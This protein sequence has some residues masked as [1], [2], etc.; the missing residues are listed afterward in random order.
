MAAKYFYVT[1]YFD[2]LLTHTEYLHWAEI[3][4]GR[5]KRLRL[6]ILDDFMRHYAKE[7]WEMYG[8]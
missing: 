2:V 4:Y 6:L 5:G 8:S 3:S 1:D 7:E